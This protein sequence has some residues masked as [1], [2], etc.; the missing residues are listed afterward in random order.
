MAK[1]LSTRRATTTGFSLSFLMTIILFCCG[2]HQFATGFVAPTGRPTCTASKFAGVVSAS[3]LFS[4]KEEESTTSGEDSKTGSDEVL[5][6]LLNK[7]DKSKEK[8]KSP[9]K[10]DNKAMAFLK[11]KGLVGGAANK[12]F[13]NAVGSDEGTTGKQPAA[14]RDGSAGGVPKK[15]KL[16]Y[17]TCIETGVIDDFTETFPMT[18]SGT[19]WRGVSDRVMGGVSDGFIERKT[20][21]DK[22][23]NVLTG[24]VSLKNNGGFIQMVT[25]LPTDPVQPSV[26]A[27]D[28]DGVE[29]LVLCNHEPLQFNI[30][31]RTPGTLQ[32]ASYRH[33]V[34]VET[35]GVWERVRIPFSSFEAYGDPDLPEQLDYSRLRRI[36]IV[37]IG[38]EMDV[39]LA[40]AELKF[41]CVI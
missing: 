6:S 40:L 16:A 25:D 36:G 23:A 14:Q 32:Q 1:A 26:D 27:S 12:S 19:E 3:N 39:D 10:S 9:K 11:Q 21:N 4:S 13:V 8:G 41:Y 20:V 15:A 28:Y 29:L 34:K 7:L 2:C 35:P 18:S 5:D 24:H 30:H 33:T 31:L 37:A 38:E 17:K 22:V